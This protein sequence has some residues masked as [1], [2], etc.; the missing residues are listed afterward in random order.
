[1]LRSYIIIAIRNFSRH[2]L[3]TVINVFGLSVGLCSA[4]LIGLYAIDE[5]SYDRF[6]ED[7]SSIYRI[8]S[9]FGFSEDALVPLGPYMLNEYVLENVPE[10]KSSTR[11]RPETSDEFWLR[12]DD[13]T[14]Y[15]DNFLLADTNFFTF[16]SFPLLQ[17]SPEQVL[18]K[19]NSVVISESAALTYFGDENPIG[20]VLYVH[21]EH[22]VIITGLMK[23]F[24]ANSHFK[25]SFVGN[26]DIAR[27]YM[28]YV[29]TNWGSFG[30]YYYFHME[31]FVNTAE[32]SDKINM[33]MAEAV[34]DIAEWAT[35]GVQPLLDIRLHSANVA[36]DIGSQGNITL[37]YGLVAVA[38]V[39]LLLASV[40]YINMYT[41]L[42]TRRKKEVGIRKVM[43]AGKQN[44]FWQSMTESGISVLISFSIAMVLAELFIPYAN[45]LSG[46]VLSLSVLFQ[47]PNMLY[48]IVILTAIAFISG[49]YPAIVVGR[50]MPADILKSGSLAGISNSFWGRLFNLRFRQILIV[51]QFCCASALIILSLSISRQIN[52]MLDKDYGYDPS[53]LI[54]LNNPQGANQSSRF[55]SLKNSLEQYPEIEV[56]SA[57]LNVPSER[58][59]NF[60]Y[61]RMPEDEHELMIGNINVHQDYF[62]AIGSKTLAGRTFKTEYGTESTNIVINRSAARALGYSPEDI[63]NKDVMAQLATESS[64][65]I[66]VIEDIHFF[67]LHEAVS[68][69]LFTTGHASTPYGKILVRAGNRQINKAI[70][71]AEEVWQR[72]HSGYP[73]SYTVIGDRLR[74][75]YSSEEQTKDL[76]GVFMILAILIS[77]MGL[78]ALAS[79]VLATRIKEIAV[80]KVLGATRF[81]VLKMIG[82]EFS[83]LV[84]ISTLLALPLAYF[85]IIRWLDTFAYRQEISYAYF[86]LAPLI[87][88]L[89]AWLT[90]SYH[91]YRSAKT[92]A[93]EALKYE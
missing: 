12:Y 92:S 64:R 73:F 74:S 19:P 33:V 81:Q 53:Q 27:K 28:E 18:S 48:V 80:R 42:A 83:I 41:A 69:M 62:A 21:D 70:S 87:I 47:F 40:N 25:A 34:P 11:I 7:A 72:E 71:I 89:A 68:P 44:I 51:F 15:I 26:A 49:F 56:V 91:A 43:G 61:A 3:S 8:Q 20:K 75:Q 29:F 23:D 57:G 45:D 50:Y 39:I 85:V 14:Y 76:V 54:L 4:L 59:N 46:K 16:F 58:L 88:L 1:M 9:Q 30:F 55:Y 2:K 66:G 24:P 6:H 38:V 90:I 36:Y 65:V 13:Q 17:G 31:D 35:I 77:L 37:L 5:F 32:V 67:S 86:I 93:A 78:F 82:S 52:Y 10:I 79:F 22:P 63:I 84:L 60:T